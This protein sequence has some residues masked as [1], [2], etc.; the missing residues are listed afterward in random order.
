MY[1]VIVIGAGNGGLVASLTLQKAGKKVLLLEAGSGA[2]GFATSF[3]R[4]RFEFDAFL[5][6]LNGYGLGNE[7]EMTKLFERLGIT[8]MLEYS[9]IANDYVVTLNTHES[10]LIPH[11]FSTFLLKM[12][13]VVPGCRESIEN[14][15]NLCKESVIALKHVEEKRKG[16]EEL[17]EQECP[18]FLEISTCSLEEVFEKLKMPKKIREI[19]ASSW[20]FYGSPSRDLSFVSFA[21]SFY[22]RFTNGVTYPIKRSYALSLVI[23]EEF[24]RLGGTIRLFSK[25]EKVLFTEDQI[26][27]VQVADG[28]IF[29]A[30]HLISNVSPNVFFGSF[31]PKD[32]QTK[33]MN[34][35]CNA[36]TLG[37]RGFSV[38]LGLNKSPQELGITEARYL[39]YDS[40]DSNIEAKRMREIYHT[41]CVATVYENMVRKSSSITT[42]CISSLL[43]GDDFDKVVTSENYFA[44]KD[45]IARHFIEVFERATN[46]SIVDAIEEIEVATP[47]TF[48]RYGGHPSGVT[49]GYLAKGYD[50]LLP[51]ML[52][53]RKEQFL[54][55]VHF[56]GGFGTRMSDFVSTYLSGEDAALLTLEDIKEEESYV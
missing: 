7:S 31:L 44:L 16:F 33:E 12:E 41:G 21:P 10:Y 52:N 22:A 32:K 8:N 17:L 56:C 29:Y 54:N 51:R 18:H 2:G 47:V 34:Q 28:S 13:E 55:H 53:E 14:F 43:F 38:Y 39:I 42:L 9:E 23:Q 30:K 5:Q 15:W 11:S 48:A 4:G 24:E 49:Y 6:G 50:N 40:L 46:T 37:A 27:G 19:L 20:I 45:K 3:V 36:R 1:D 26:S 25:V 35:I